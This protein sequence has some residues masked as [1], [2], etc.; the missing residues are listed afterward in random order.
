M[1]NVQVLAQNKND[2]DLT[3]FQKN[4]LIFEFNTFFDLNNDG[5]LSYKVS[6]MCDNLFFICPNLASFLKDFQWAKDR[7]C[8]MSGWQINSEKYKVT[9]KLFTNIWTSL[10]EVADT[11][12][13]GRITR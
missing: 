9:E 7:I 4:K 1:G 12:N 10:V 13:D 6:I 3:E 5:Y 2:G 8:Q 11:D